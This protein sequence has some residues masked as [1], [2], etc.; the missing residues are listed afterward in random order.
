MP[1]IDDLPPEQMGVLAEQGLAKAKLTKT[2]KEILLS[3]GLAELYQIIEF[4]NQT[5]PALE[6]GMLDTIL[7]KNSPSLPHVEGT[8]PVLFWLK[9]YAKKISLFQDLAGW[10]QGSPVFAFRSAWKNCIRFHKEIGK[11]TVH[12]EII[13]KDDRVTDLNVCLIDETSREK[14]AFEIELFTGNRCIESITATSRTP[15][16]F[17]AIQVGNYFLRLSDSKGEITS[18]LLRI[19]Q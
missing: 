8:K 7:K 12:L 10:N 9:F 6:T 4:L 14:A 1:I 18:L 5:V 13:K 16:S 17:S 3:R 2:E 15:V 11:I 19:D